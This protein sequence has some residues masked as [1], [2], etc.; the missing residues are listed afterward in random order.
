MMRLQKRLSN[1]AIFSFE[2]RHPAGYQLIRPILG[3]CQNLFGSRLENGFTKIRL[4]DKKTLVYLHDY[5]S[6]L[7]YLDQHFVKSGRPV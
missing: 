7:F 1:V 5:I 4:S 3:K 2:G 6:G